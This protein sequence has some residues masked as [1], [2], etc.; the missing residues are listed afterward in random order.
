MGNK[1]NKSSEYE[2][3]DLDQDLDLNTTE[4]IKFSFMKKV[5]KTSCLAATVFI[6][7]VSLS[8]CCWGRYGGYGHGYHGHG[9]GH[10]HRDFYYR[11][12]R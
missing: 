9:E 7:M 12:V 5:R 3:N 1:I 6:V 8:S 4:H 11:P 10:H 2:C